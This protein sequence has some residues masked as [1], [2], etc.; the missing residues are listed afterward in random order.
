MGIFK[1]HKKSKPPSGGHQSAKIREEN[2]NRICNIVSKCHHF[3]FVDDGN[4][5]IFAGAY[6][7]TVR[8][9]ARCVMCPN[10]T[11]IDMSPGQIN[12]IYSLIM[13]RQSFLMHHLRS[14]IMAEHIRGLRHRF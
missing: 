5:I 8:D 11:L 1:K 13:E 7:F 12:K 2:F 3:K 10:G 9:G 4:T 14:R 6:K